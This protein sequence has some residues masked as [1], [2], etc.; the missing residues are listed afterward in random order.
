MRQFRQVSAK[1]YKTEELNQPRK[2]SSK[3]TLRKDTQHRKGQASQDNSEAK[4]SCEAVRQ[5][6]HL[7]SWNRHR[8]EL[9]YGDHRIVI[10]V[11]F[12]QFSKLQLLLALPEESLDTPEVKSTMETGQQEIN[13]IS[14]A[15]VHH[16]TCQSQVSSL[17]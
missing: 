9:S 13:P 8:W 15:S 17:H 16:P 10:S 1:I 11:H 4:D 5:L 6:L 2:S 7:P 3:I 14:D 12:P